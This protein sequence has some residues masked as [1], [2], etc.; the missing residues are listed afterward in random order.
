MLPHWNDFSMSRCQSLNIRWFVFN[1]LYNVMA[2][3]KSLVSMDLID[4]RSQSN[5]I[6]Q[7]IIAVPL[8]GG[9]DCWSHQNKTKQNTLILCRSNSTKEAVAKFFMKNILFL[10][11][12]VSLPKDTISYGE[13]MYVWVKINVLS[14]YTH[15]HA[16]TYPVS[17]DLLCFTTD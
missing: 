9:S 8:G 16:Y 4:Q 1:L 15:I 11:H 7:Q 17:K 14:I 6:L 2:N 13:G 5:I 10:Y 12:G 3:V